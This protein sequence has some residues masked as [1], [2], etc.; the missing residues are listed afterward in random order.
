MIRPTCVVEGGLIA[1][2]SPAIGGRGEGGF[3][4]AGLIDCHV[5]LSGPDTQQIFARH[6]VTTA[7]DM[8]SPPALVTRLRDRPGMTDIRSSMLVTT[9]PASEHARRMAAVPGAAESHVAGVADA[10]PA[11]ARR[12]RAGGG[13]PQ[14]RD[15]PA[16]FRP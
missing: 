15:R 7:L 6:G 4:L 13:L 12:A 5:H 14:D 3:V 9:S 16:R 10:E 2:I 11:V 1:A 8:G